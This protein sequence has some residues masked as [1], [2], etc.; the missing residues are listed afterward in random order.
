MHPELFHYLCAVQTTINPLPMKPRSILLLCSLVVCLCVT[1]Q[2]GTTATVTLSKD[3][4][5]HYL[6]LGI[7]D[8]WLINP[9]F[10]G[11]DCMPPED[12]WFGD[13]TYHSLHTNFP[14]LS[15]AYWYSLNKWL[16]LGGEVYL[17]YTSDKYRYVLTD[18]VSSSTCTFNIAVLGSIRFQYFNRKYVGIYSAASLGLL[19]ILYNNGRDLDDGY[20][21][22]FQLT[23]VGFRFGN[24]VHATLEL[25]FGMKG[26]LNVGIG[27]R[28]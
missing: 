23:G 9:E 24:R 17:Q 22:A 13:Y 16:Q 5:R 25:G 4:P 20:F 19:S 1:A 10:F 3:Y 27:A 8:P 2:T 26:W 7:G 12:Y 14:V 21:P 15:L 11:C 28:F 18:A 6:Q